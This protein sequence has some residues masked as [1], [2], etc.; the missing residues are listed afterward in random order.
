MIGVSF[1]CLLYTSLEK[2]PQHADRHGEAERHDS[3]EQRRQLEGKPFEMCIRDRSKALSIDAPGAQIQSVGT[4][5]LVVFMGMPGEESTFT[6]RI[7][8]NNFENMGMFMFM[9]PATLSSLDIISDLKDVKD[10][11]SDSS[12]SLYSG[13]LLYTSRCV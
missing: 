4:Y 13:C 7:G 12:D 2:F 9:T 11:L 6:V 1:S 3:Q 10:R 8:S 5:K